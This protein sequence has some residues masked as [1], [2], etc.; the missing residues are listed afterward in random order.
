MAVSEK[1]L[2]AGFSERYY[3]QVNESINSL[4]E[5]T[6]RVDER[7]INMIRKQELT[8]EK[9]SSQLEALS[10]LNTKVKILETSTKDISEKANDMHKLELRVQLLE[11][12]SSNQENRWKTIF[13]FAIQLVWVILAA[14]LLF[15]LGIQAPAVP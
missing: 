14:F 6:T 10:D 9:I 5:L 13:G 2:P 12:S 3:S 1:P 8:D 7:V 4:I 11:N 15:K